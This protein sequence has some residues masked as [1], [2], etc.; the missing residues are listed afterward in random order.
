[1]FDEDDFQEEIRTHLEIA[2]AEREA[3]GVDP[4]SARLASLKD[5]GNVSLTAEAA[6]RVWIPRWIDAALDQLR[7]A[8]YAIR[9]LAKNPVFSLAVVGVLALGVGAN[10]MVF[11]ML[12]SMALA[13]LSGIANSAQLGVVVNAAG[14]T[15]TTGLSY[16]DYQ[17]IRDHDRV[18]D[19]LAASGLTSANFGRGR[20]AR[21]MYCELVS[22]NYFQVL[23]IRAE[24]GRTFLPSD[25]IAPGRH[26]YAVLND[27]FW[28]R[29]LAADPDILGKTIEINNFPLTIVGVADP[30]FHGTIV[31]Y[32]TEVFVPLM[33]AAQLGVNVGS[34][35]NTA[36]SDIFA[37]RGAGVF[38]VLGHLR[39]GVTFANA[40]A[41]VDALSTALFQ[42]AALT[43][44]GQHLRLVHIWE[45]PFGGQTFL[46]PGLLV[47]GA[48]GLLVLG[49]A[50]ANIAGLVLVRGISRRGELAVRLAL[51]A[52]RARIVRLLVVENLVLA[53][54]GA[55]LGMVLASY[56]LPLL[57][58]SAEAMA[59]PQRLFFNVPLD[60]SLMAFA[61]FVALGSALA[62]GFVPAVQSSR[63]DLVEAI[64]EDASPRGASRGRLRAW[65]VVAQVAV[66]LILL[67]GAGL[68]TRSVDAARRVYPGFDASHTT[69]IEIDVRSNGY[70]DA[71]GRVFYRR[72][73]DA[74][75]GETG[76]ESVTL[77]STTPLNLV[78]TREARVAIDGY[79]PRRDE[80]LSFQVNTIGPD[81]FR[82]LRIPLAAGRGFDDR[83]DENGRPA[84]VINRTFAE[85]FWS[86]A[87]AA[88][89]QR[90]KVGAGDWRTVVG[91]ASDV[92]YSQVNEAPMPFIYMPFFQSY[93]ANMT[94][95]A[96]GAAP[97]NVVVDQARERIAAIDP[98]LAFI[99]AR[100]LDEATR[101]ATV[102]FEFLSTMLLAFGAAGMVLA[103]MG[104]YGLVSYA[105]RQSTHEIGIRMALGASASSVVRSFVAR[106]LRLGA[107][108]AAI[109]VFVA[110]AGARLMQGSLFGV[111]PAD[112]VSYARAL[113]IVIGGVALATLV[114]AWRAARTNPLTALRHQ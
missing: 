60:R 81:Y 67:V 79:A 98:D 66:S 86:S 75:R 85:R 84:V 68:A 25:E 8:R 53:V 101:G 11:T 27:G 44:V 82:T 42:D 104:T 54:P 63:V 76:I 105:A 30:S 22:G 94:V 34:L 48:M 69:A 93:R 70:S 78:G 59:A 7:D 99:H 14:R 74:L 46:L 23:G 41:Q 64:N 111:S 73:L 19:G 112:T 61:A 65:L 102:L 106:G 90:V 58:R 17:F 24:R 29:D 32:D 21:P 47:L 40:G 4:R 52:T 18:F 97:V 50:C 26:P 113:A 15:R 37:D 77:A 36:T 114:P 89:G 28:R 49:I 88:V 3:D 56:G 57:V 45:S 91:V 109:G 55:I 16:H 31:G 95:H 87:A 13:P 35:E 33:M 108:G 96:R 1:M 72:L 43:D 12:E 5:F 107:F 10:T 51:G 80:D 100:P 62:F 71:R 103:G 6:R 38:D 110:F 39:P 83:D 2:A 92:K 20:G 9:T